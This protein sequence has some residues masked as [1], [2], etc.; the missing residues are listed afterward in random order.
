MADILD[1]YNQ[2]QILR[3]KLSNAQTRG[4]TVKQLVFTGLQDKQISEQL[5]ISLKY[6]YRLKTQ[7]GLTNKQL[8]KKYIGGK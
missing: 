7:Y 6:W 2:Y 3:E 5:N 8:A 4:D 1:T